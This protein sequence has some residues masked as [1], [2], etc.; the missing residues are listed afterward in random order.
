MGQSKSPTGGVKISNALFCSVTSSARDNGPAGFASNNFQA[1]LYSWVVTDKVSFRKVESPRFHALLQYLNPRC[2]R[3]KPSHQ[4]LSRTI[5]EIYDKQLCVITEALV[6]AATKIHFSFDLLTLKNRLALL[7]LV[8]QFIDS[9][10]RSKSILLDLPRQKVRH[11]G[12]N[13]ANTVAEIIC[14]YGL[15][16][17]VGCFI[18]DKGRKISKVLGFL[19]TK[20]H[21][22]PQR[23]WLPCVGHISTFAGRPFFSAKISMHLSAKSKISS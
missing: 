10:G 8:T 12:S 4:T 19:G 16:K 7:G 1:L 13:T 22:D 14:H 2:E 5:G 21:F 18:S 11:T 20:F 15:E 23:R 9:A 3:L 6:A 17:K